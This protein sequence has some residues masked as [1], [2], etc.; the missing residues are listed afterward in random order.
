MLIRISGSAEVYFENGEQGDVLQLLSELDG[1]ESEDVCA[2]YLDTDFADLGITGGTVKLV[3]NAD[4]ERFQVVTEYTSPVELD[5]MQLKR[6]L[7]DTCGQWTDG[8]GENCFGELSDRLGVVIN[9]YPV[10]SDDDLRIEQ[11]DDGGAVEQPRSVLAKAAREGD[12]STLRAELNAGADLEVRLQRYT[13]LQLAVIYGQAG[14]ALE[15]IAR[16]ADVNARD[17]MDHD[18]LMLTTLSNSMTDED[19][20]RV[21]RA[22]LERGAMVHGVNGPTAEPEAGEH[23]PLYIAE[24]RK[25][26][27]LAGV[28]RSFGATR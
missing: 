4:A 12:L 7:D 27:R 21:A 16:G 8:I 18:P 3:Y 26:T 19:A 20:A 1:A 28:L 22:L 13:P 17:P 9:I 14:A 10:G 23:T 24:L 15:L 25:K 11:I 5:L 6:L 2:D